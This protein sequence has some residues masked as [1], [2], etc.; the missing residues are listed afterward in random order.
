MQRLTATIEQVVNRL[1]YTLKIINSDTIKISDSRRG[2]G[3][4]IGFI[5]HLRIVNTS[6]Y[7]SLT[8]LHTPNISGTTAQITSSLH[9]LTFN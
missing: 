9:S 1:Y 4:D 6:D 3:L 2:F 5:G 7:N 8:G